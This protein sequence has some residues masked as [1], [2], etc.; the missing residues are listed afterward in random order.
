MDVADLEYTLPPEA[1]AQTPAEPRESA[2][3]LVIGR[4][5]GALADR[6][7]ADLP[8]LL[9]PGD[10]LVVNDSRVIPAR[11]HAEDAQGRPVE[12]LFLEP[13]TE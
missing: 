9:R 3:L 10:C 1:I 6:R 12:L 4:R 2:R 7:V 5:T 11:V 8:D 13:V